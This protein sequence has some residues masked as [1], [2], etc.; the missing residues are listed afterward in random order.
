MPRKQIVQYD[1]AASVASTDRFLLQQGAVGTEFTHATVSQLLAGGLAA[2]F[3]VPK[4]TVFTSDGTFTK[5]PSA[6]FM[7]VYVCGGG[8][9]G[10]GGARGAAL[11]AKPGGAGGGGAHSRSIALPHR[12]YRLL[13]Q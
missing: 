1:A 10:G 11:T 3:A 4:V 2:T 5:D 7:D 13:S 6:K 12:Q 8:G 9:G